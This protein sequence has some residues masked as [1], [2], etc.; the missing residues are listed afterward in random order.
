[1][2]SRLLLIVGVLGLALGSW[3]TLPLAQV[4]V[5][6]QVV[7]GRI[8]DAVIVPVGEGQARFTVFFE[9][10][11]PG[12]DGRTWA[13]GAAQ[14]DERL[15]LHDEPLLPIVQ[16]VAL[17]QTLLAQSRR[18]VY[19]PANP[20]VAQPFII[21]DVGSN[22]LGYRQGFFILLAGSLIVTMG[23]TARRQRGRG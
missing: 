8:L 6:G 2:L 7:W 5:S 1:M 22:G 11:L 21:T 9:Y 19:L 12:S 16:A 20:A 13:Q 3:L 18:R 4:Y 23:L 15:E 14:A 10:P 17:R